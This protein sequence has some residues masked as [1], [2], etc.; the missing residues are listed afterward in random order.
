MINVTDSQPIYANNSYWTYHY[1][2]NT[3]ETLNM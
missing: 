3:K 1:V 2:T